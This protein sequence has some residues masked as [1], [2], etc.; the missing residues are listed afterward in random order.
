MNH[1]YQ[2]VPYRLK[3]KNKRVRLETLTD[4]LGGKG[5]C[6]VA[7]LGPLADAF[8]LQPYQLLIRD[9]NATEPQEAVT[10]RQMRG[11]KQIR[12]DK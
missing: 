1:H 6:N 3:K 9:L 2:G 11:L 12:E 8:G 5:G 7:S 10:A 4:I